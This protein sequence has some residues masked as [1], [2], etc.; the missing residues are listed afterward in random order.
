MCKISPWLASSG[1]DL[2]FNL[3]QMM[4]KDLK[5]MLFYKFIKAL[6]HFLTKKKTYF[7][8]KFRIGTDFSVIV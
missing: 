1:F 7:S 3:L 8:L 4:E 6:G 2:H 5:N